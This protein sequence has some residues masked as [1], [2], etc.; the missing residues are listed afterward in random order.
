MFDEDVLKRKTIKEIYQDI[1]ETKKLLTWLILGYGKHGL[2]I[3]SNV[4]WYWVKENYNV[5]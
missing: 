2:S 3:N 4:T 1:E 5:D